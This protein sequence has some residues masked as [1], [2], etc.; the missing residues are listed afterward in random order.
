[1]E[2]VRLE[3]IPGE[4]RLGEF[5]DTDRE[6]LH[7]SSLNE[8]PSISMALK[9]TIYKARLELA[10]MDR[11]L[12]GTYNVTIARHP[13]ETDERMMTR[14]LAF[15]HNVPGSTDQGAL[16]LAKDLW[17]AGEPALWRKDLTGEIQH[18]IEVGQ[19]DEKRLMQASARAGRVS[20]YASHANISKWWAGIGPK[21]SRTSTI[22]A[23]HVSMGQ[24]TPL[25]VLTNR[26]MKL[27][28][29][30]QDGNVW[31]GD[32]NQSVEVSLQ[33]LN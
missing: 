28:V 8:N 18:W 29:T 20:V 10:D 33:R 21:V 17:D 7:W 3:A 19:P 6:W 13:S 9:A 32:G 16:E 11:S 23:W 12:Y 25:S 31:V 15:A 22:A 2:E 5:L 26:T 4:A 14:L 24:S 1:M 30:I 27:D